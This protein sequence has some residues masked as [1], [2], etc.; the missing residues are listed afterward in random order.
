MHKHHL[1]EVAVQRNFSARFPRPVVHVGRVVAAPLVLK[2]SKP[3]VLLVLFGSVAIALTHAPS[4]Q[5]KSRFG[6]E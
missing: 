1:Q 2:Q 5:K 6:E 4:S 3:L